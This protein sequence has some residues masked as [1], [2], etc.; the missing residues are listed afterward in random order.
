MWKILHSIYWWWAMCEQMVI[1][2]GNL[3]KSWNWTIKQIDIISIELRKYT[4][5]KCLR[6]IG[7]FVQSE[8]SHGDISMI[9][10]PFLFFMSL[11]FSFYF[12]SCSSFF[13]YFHLDRIWMAGL[14]SR[15]RLTQCTWCLCDKP[16]FFFVCV[17]VRKVQRPISVNQP[18]KNN[19]NMLAWIYTQKE[20]ETL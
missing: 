9:T 15:I 5:L 16:L 11:V 13:I 6:L 2:W 8:N 4:Q 10:I 14:A 7:P 12:Y 17:C 19:E 20:K 18:K 3:E 1:I